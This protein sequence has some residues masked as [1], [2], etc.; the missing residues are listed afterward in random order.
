MAAWTPLV[1]V[2]RR[3]RLVVAATLIAL[4]AAG[5]YAAL[6]PRTYRATASIFFSLQYGQTAS[7]LVQGSTYTQDQVASFARLATTPV[8]LQS[9]IDDLDL[10][11]RPNALAGRIQASAAVDT[12]IVDVSATDATPGGSSRLANDVARRLSET[13]EQLAPRDSKGAPT[14]RAT[15]VARAEVPEAAASP[16]MPLDLAAGLIIGLLLGVGLA[17]AR[18]ALDN[19][20]RDA[21][22]V[23]AVT[24]LPVVGTIGARSRRERHPVVVE[25][26]PH[27]PQAEFFR[28]L[29]TNLQFLAV[30]GEA[31]E[32]RGLRTVMVTS[33]LA[34]EG[35]TTVAANLAAALAETGRVLLVDADLR[36]P[37]VAQLL[38]LEGSAGLSTALIGR[39]SAL[40]LVQD[41][42][43]AGLQVLPSGL[44][45][46]N[47]GELLNSP[48]MHRVLAELRRSYDYVVLDAAPLLPVAD[49]VI[50]S[51]VVDGTLVVANVT[52]VRR[53]QLAHS[54]GSL[55]QVK[56]RVLGVVLNQVQRHDPAYGYEARPE[57]GDAQQ[58]ADRVAAGG[59]DR[60]L[61][62]PTR[63]RATERAAAPVPP[64]V[65]TPA[66]VAARQGQEQGGR[67]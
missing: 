43:S 15:T 30:P 17:W 18:E 6:V 51:R 67:R 36:R 13:V 52:K 53:H 25:S 35:K 54:V 21:E 42:G 48:A 49:A 27:S 24:E 64:P 63:P 46:P 31:L 11:E 39:A 14:V 19:R 62:A 10:R 20:V 57:E 47:A 26:E 58:F 23:A 44:V 32:D 61:I 66:S 37:A 4:L 55:A 9:V 28:Q 16:D 2:R 60:A 40:D 34:A 29:A 56:A 38:G 45:P 33:S 8:V 22:V 65:A 12:V 3:W 1:A 5:A 59:T 7:D 50:L 41:W